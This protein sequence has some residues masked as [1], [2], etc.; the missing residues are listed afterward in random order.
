[1]DLACDEAKRLG[2]EYL[3]TEHILLGLLDDQEGLAAR[4]LRSRG[5][6]VARVRAELELIELEDAAN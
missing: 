2:K 3:G 6:N 1:L 5:A 4:V